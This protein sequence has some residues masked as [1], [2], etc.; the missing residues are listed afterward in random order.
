MNA[1]RSQARSDVGV[2]RRLP[3]EHPVAVNYRDNTIQMVEV[4]ARATRY[5][6]NS[7]CTTRMK[8]FEPSHL[9]GF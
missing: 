3:W 7:A 6:N 1:V 9:Q 8:E 2:W 4:G 5:R